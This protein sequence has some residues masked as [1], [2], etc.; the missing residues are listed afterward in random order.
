[1]SDRQSHEFLHRGFATRLLCRIVLSKLEPGVFNRR[2]R[3]HA[4]MWHCF[5]LGN[6]EVNP[7]FFASSCLVSGFSEKMHY[8]N[9]DYTVK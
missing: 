1:M 7:D 2:V 8:N 9:R 3:V 5:L 6:D 4:S